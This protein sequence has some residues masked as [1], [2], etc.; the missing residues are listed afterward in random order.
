[1]RRAYTWPVRGALALV[2]AAGSAAGSLAGCAEP[3]LGTSTH[4]VVGGT[5]SPAGRFPSV[6][7]LIA[8]GAAYCTGTL[9]A[10]AVVLTAAHCLEGRTTAPGFTL[11]QDAR[12]AVA[13]VPGVAMVAHPMWDIDRPIADGPTLYYDLGLVRLADPIDTVT[14]AIV[15]SKIEAMGLLEGRQLTIV[16]YGQT[17][18]GDAA[19][20]GVMHHAVAPIVNQSPSEMQLSEPGAPQN[21]Y[22]DSGGPGFIDL[23]AGERVAGVVSRGATA[24]R[25]CDQGGIDT[26]LDFFLDWLIAEV[27][28]VCVGGQACAGGLLPGP[29]ITGFGADITGGCA[30]VGGGGG[31]AGVLAAIVPWLLRRRRR[32][33]I[34]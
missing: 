3:D 11:A 18:D 29:E 21:C 8:D 23:G 31:A 34:G 30:D 25:T 5:P 32:R 16:G 28:E 1:M 24:A 10:P 14:P 26:R 19:S 20:A 33:Q 6:G 17:I 2:L 4:D 13:V 15:P 12:G 9:I 22:G 27:P 7:A